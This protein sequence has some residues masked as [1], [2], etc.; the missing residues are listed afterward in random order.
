MFY[1]HMEVLNKWLLRM[2]TELL[3]V[4]QVLSDDNINSTDKVSSLKQSETSHLLYQL[5]HHC[6]FCGFPPEK[7]ALLKICEVCDTFR[8]CS[9]ECFKKAKPHHEFLCTDQGTVEMMMT[10]S[11]LGPAQCAAL[12]AA[13]RKIR[14]GEVM[15]EPLRTLI[16]P[17][18]NDKEDDKEDN[19]G[20]KKFGK[21]VPEKL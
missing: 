6:H 1:P 21:L 16:L 11:T 5:M 3:N 15:T 9:E 8:Y 17:T 18:K 20:F 7:G 2:Y 12:V 14:K 10:F 19:F 13:N 4:R